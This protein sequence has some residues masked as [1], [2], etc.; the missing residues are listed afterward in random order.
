MHMGQV[1][2]KYGIVSEKH[3]MVGINNLICL[4][5]LQNVHL[6]P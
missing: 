2:R 6:P 5:L 3:D 1:L 4:A